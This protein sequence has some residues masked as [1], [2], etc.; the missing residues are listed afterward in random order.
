LT[1][2]PKQQIN[3]GKHVAS[4]GDKG[5]TKVVTKWMYKYHFS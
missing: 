5:V 1:Q 3:K 4:M 2:K